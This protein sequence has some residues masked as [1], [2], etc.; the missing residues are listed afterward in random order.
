MFIEHVLYVK[1]HSRNSD[2]SVTK[3]KKKNGGLL[4]RKERGFNGHKNNKNKEIRFYY[5]VIY[6]VEK[7]IKKMNNFRENGV[8]G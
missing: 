2:Q 8:V 6:A 4:S 7:T 3:V 1:H 5:M